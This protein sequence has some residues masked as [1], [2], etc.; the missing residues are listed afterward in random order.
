M[1]F[2]SNDE[3]RL[4]VIPHV[5]DDVEELFRLL[6][7]EHRG[8]LVQNE[9][10]RAAVQHL[11]DLHRLLF[12][13]GHLVGLF[14]GVDVKPVFGRDL[15]D[16]FGG[17]FEVVTLAVAD[18]ENDVLGRAEHADQFKMLVHHADFI[19]ERILRRVDDDRLAVHEDL[20]FVGTVDAGDHVHQ[21]RFAGAVLAENGEHLA[22]FEVEV[23]VLVGDD[24]GAERLGDV[25]QLKRI[26]VS[27]F[28][29]H[30]DRSFP[31]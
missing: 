21:R 9:D 15:R 27:A 26:F 3:D 18:A 4:T 29:T 28:K 31:I 11:D 24:F 13:D 2:M 22:L 17:A 12:G 7:R 10:V 20:A 16:F 8:R 14:G 1:Q 23:H 19:L 25:P 6:R 30:G 5:A